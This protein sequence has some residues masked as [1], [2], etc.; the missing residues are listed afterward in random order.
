MHA[1]FDRKAQKKAT[2]LSV[3][4]DLLAKARKLNIN[5]SATLEAALDEALKKRYREQWLADNRQAMAAYNTH[6]EE[7]GVFSD[8]LRGF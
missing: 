1:T 6:V 8:G 3:N 7:H 4:E 5:L 2:N